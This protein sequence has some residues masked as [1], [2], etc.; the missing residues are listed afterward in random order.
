MLLPLLSYRMFPA[1][2]LSTLKQRVGISV[3]LISCNDNRFTGPPER[4]FLYAQVNK[5]HKEVNTLNNALLERSPSHHRFFKKKRE[6]VKQ[7]WQ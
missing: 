3:K 4:V 1:M 7:L 6:K 5:Q 2:K